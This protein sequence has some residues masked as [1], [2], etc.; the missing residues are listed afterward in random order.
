MA[1]RE[2]HGTRSAPVARARHTGHLHHRPQAAANHDG[3]GARHARIL[4]ALAAATLALTLALPI[5]TLLRL[6]RAS[7]ETTG[8]G[9]VAAVPA[10]ALR[11]PAASREPIP[12]TPQAARRY[13]PAAP[14]IS[15]I[16]AI[17]AVR[18]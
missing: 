1:A 4:Y 7:P 10:P 14:A 2:Q 17:T 15:A 18:L 11:A 12:L 13:G 8:G 3:K 9:A 16:A 5:G 6:H